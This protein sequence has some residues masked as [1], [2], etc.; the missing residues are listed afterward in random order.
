VSE[1][2]LNV[3]HVV[4]RYGDHAAV[5][6]ISFTVAP[7]EF[8]TLLGPSGCGKTTTLRLL[9][10]LETPDAGE[11]VLAGRCLAAPNRGVLVPIDKR[12]MGMVFQS[13]AIWPHLTVFENVAFPLRIRH[14]RAADVDQRV[15]RALEMVGLGAFRHRPSQQLSG[16]QQQRVAVAR[17]IVHAPAVLLFDEPLSNLDAKLRDHTRAEIRKLQ[18]ELGVATI[19]VTH[20]QAEALSLSDR[21]LV[22]HDG[23]IRQQGTPDQIYGAPLDAFVADVVGPANFIQVTVTGA[24]ARGID[25]VTADGTPIHAVAG[26]ATP[27]PG[28]AMIRPDRVIIAAATGLPAATNRL[29]GEV[30][31]RLFLGG[32]H[33]YLVA[34]GA[35]LIRVMSTV[36]IAEG[37]AV[38]VS[39][40]TAD[41]I[42]LGGGPLHADTTGETITWA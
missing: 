8:F 2:L 18:R 27:G 23:R 34:V 17:A 9:A 29:H 16:G 32:H 26:N 12:G 15:T 38:M 39:F 10:G 5:N 40:D 41:C 25:A 4:K 7:G 33:E 35:T 36:L 42:I 1:A 37:E 20:D 14:L 11:I 24:S 30:R 31:Q 22:M 13:Y 28:Q 6:D 3:S 19:Y 21:I